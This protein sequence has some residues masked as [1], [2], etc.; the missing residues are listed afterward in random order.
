MVA[1][2]VKGGDQHSLCY[3]CEQPGAKWIVQNGS[4]RETVHRGCGKAIAKSTHAKSPTKVYPSKELRLE[5]KARRFWTEKFNKAGL[6]TT[7]R[8]KPKK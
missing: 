7:G 1:V 8:P 5:W 2:A 6:D 4:F 3:L